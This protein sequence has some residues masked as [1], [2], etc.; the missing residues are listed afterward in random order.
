MAFDLCD[1]AK[2][3]EVEEML[4]R[5]KGSEEELYKRICLKYYLIK[6]REVAPGEAPAIHYEPPQLQSNQDPVQT[7]TGRGRAAKAYQRL[8]PR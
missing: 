3:D 4:E 7:G 1:P 2:L 8:D 6:K 5:H